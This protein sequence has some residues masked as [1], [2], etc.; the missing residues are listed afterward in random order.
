MTVTVPAAAKVNLWLRIGAVG[1]DGYHP[2]DTL[3]CALELGDEVTVRQRPDLPAAELRPGFAAPLTALPDMGPPERNLAL[4]AASAFARAAGTPAGVEIALTKRIPTGAG[5]GGGSSDAAATLL[6]MARLWRGRLDGA[7]LLQVARKLGSDIPFFVS[8]APLAVGTGRGDRLMQLAPPE[9]RPVV[10]ALPPVHVPTP[11]AYA[12]L[13]EAR[14][15]AEPDRRGAGMQEDGAGDDGRGGPSVG[16]GPP[17]SRVPESLAWNE[18]EGRA[19]NDFEP[20]LFHRYPFL[21]EL[22]DLLRGKGARIALLA[23]SGSTVFGVFDDEATARSAAAALDGAFGGVGVVLTRTAPATTARATP[24]R[25][26]RPRR[27]RGP[28]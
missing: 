16:A 13:D 24:R 18:I 26:G 19:K 5:L 6:A 22:R 7:A 11:A 25:R 21:R 20:A 14:G 28:S 27:P 8:G 2:L 10:L 17:V 15:A 1:A 9:S 4:R 23:G 12:W 3:Y